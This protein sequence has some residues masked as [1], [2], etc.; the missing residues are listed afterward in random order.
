ML[1]L[2]RSYAVGFAALPRGSSQ[3][4]AVGAQALLDNIADNNLRCHAA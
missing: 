3:N 4:T 1:G 2:T